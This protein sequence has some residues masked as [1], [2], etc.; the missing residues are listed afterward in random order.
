VERISL[1]LVVVALGLC[2]FDILLAVQ[3]ISDIAVAVKDGV[4]RN[5]LLQIHTKS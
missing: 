3:T 4:A 5:L 2:R 1:R